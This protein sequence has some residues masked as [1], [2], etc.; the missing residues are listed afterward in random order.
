[1]KKIV[2]VGKSCSGKTEFSTA[3]KRKGFRVAVSHTSRP[4]RKSEEQGNSY[5]FITVEE[6]KNLLDDGSFI[7]YD[8]FNNWLYGLHFDEYEKSHVLIQTPRGLDRLIE[9][10]GRDNLIVIYMNTTEEVRKQRSIERGDDSSEVKRR[11]AADDKD[12]AEFVKNEDWD[13]AIDYKLEDKY[14]FFIDLFCRQ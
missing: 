9:K 5:H 11:L 2:L 12:F 8:E 4:I 6:F 14:D 3:L 1:M 7:E 10:V 13:I